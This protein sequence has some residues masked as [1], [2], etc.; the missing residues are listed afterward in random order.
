MTIY[1]AHFWDQYSE[2]GIPM[3][4]RLPKALVNLSTPDHW[5]LFDIK[6]VLDL[7]NGDEST[8]WVW[9][10]TYTI[11]NFCGRGKT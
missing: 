9:Q 8:Q 11:T 7:L 2:T 3:T 1:S 5:R 6:K 4:Q 10:P